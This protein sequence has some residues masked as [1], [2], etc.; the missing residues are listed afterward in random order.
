MPRR[1]PVRAQRTGK[2]IPQVARVSAATSRA[3]STFER[4]RLDPGAVARALAHWSRFVHGPLSPI[5]RH[6]LGSGCP[7][8]EDGSADWN[9]AVLKQA[10]HALPATAAREFFELVR[11]LDE[12]YLAR[13]V[14]TFDNAE[15]R[16]MLT[17][18]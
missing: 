1:R 18:Q 5:A 3:V 12:L 11:P 4:K 14:P 2:P 16:A 10:L 6:E 7:C 13:S 9:R 15:L 17:V 8:C